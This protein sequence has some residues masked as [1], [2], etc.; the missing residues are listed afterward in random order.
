MMKHN[1]TAEQVFGDIDDWALAC[2]FPI[3][4]VLH[5]GPTQSTQSRVLSAVLWLKIEL[6][7]RLCMPS[8]L[9]DKIMGN[10]PKSI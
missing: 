1:V 6:L 8:T 3:K 4:F 9:L 5:G 2:K 10:G 7:I